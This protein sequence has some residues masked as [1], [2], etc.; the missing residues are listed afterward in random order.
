MTIRYLCCWFCALALVLWPVSAQDS[1]SVATSSQQSPEIAMTIGSALSQIKSE[2]E[3]LQAYSARLD[4][5]LQASATLVEGSS[6]WQTQF[7][8]RFELWIQDFS[9]RLSKSQTSSTF[10]AVMAGA[11]WTA[12]LCLAGYA[13]LWPK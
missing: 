6:S 1:P 9:I 4:A 13:L 8:Q 5:M 2:G 7:Q 10:W 12:A 3:W 11:G